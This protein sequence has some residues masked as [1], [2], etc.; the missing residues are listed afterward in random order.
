[1]LA[2]LEGKCAIDLT[3]AELWGFAHGQLSETSGLEPAGQIVS[4]PG[5]NEPSFLRR[6]S[7]GTDTYEVG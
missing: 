6:G 7:G 5:A 1:M 2:W 4:V 3:T